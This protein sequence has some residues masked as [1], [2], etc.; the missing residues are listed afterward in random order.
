MGAV[1]DTLRNINWDDPGA[2]WNNGTAADRDP[3]ADGINIGDDGNALRDP[4]PQV[5]FGG[6][7]DGPTQSDRPDATGENTASDA[8]QAE[9][10]RQLGE[11]NPGNVVIAPNASDPVRQ[12]AAEVGVTSW[13][14]SGEFG[15]PVSGTLPGGLSSTTLLLLVAAGGAA[16]Y[17]SGGGN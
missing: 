17:L 12:A 11:T 16:I 8:A 13:D 7:S 15:T 3:D 6:V 4:T 9:L 5:D 14:D 1:E 10:V 2:P